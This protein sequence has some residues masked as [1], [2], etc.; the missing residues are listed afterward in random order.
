ME[1]QITVEDYFKELKLMEEQ[2]GQEED[3]YPWV[4]MLLMMTKD[5]KKKDISIR[6][7]HNWKKKHAPKKM[8]ESKRKQI[9]NM[10]SS[11]N[12]NDEMNGG[13]P[14][15][16]VLDKETEYYLGCV[17]IKTLNDKKWTSLKTGIHDELNVQVTKKIRQVLFDD[18]SEFDIDLEIQ[19]IERELQENQKELILLKYKLNQKVYNVDIYTVLDEKD[20]VNDREVMWYYEHVQLKHHL[21]RFRKVLYTNGLEYYFL[22]LQSDNRIDIKKLA[23]L[24]SVYK[25]Y[26]NND[27][28]LEGEVESEAEREWAKLKEGLAK[29]DWYELGI[30]IDE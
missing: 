28:I 26:K 27:F 17:E 7:T 23:N 4:Y 22:K 1:I 29:I 2:Y 16:L 30:K 8:Q 5:K 6:D 21:R 11:R 3:L 20:I 12:R 18:S 14:E 25:K 13:A 19:K 15:F 10:I 24:K 9:L